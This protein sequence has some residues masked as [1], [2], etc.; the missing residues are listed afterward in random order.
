MSAPPPPTSQCAIGRQLGSPN[1]TR[2]RDLTELAPDSPSTHPDV[3]LRDQFLPKR[4]PACEQ[5]TTPMT[6]RHLFDQ[7]LEPGRYAYG[8]IVMIN[9]SVHVPIDHIL[10]PYRQKMGLASTSTL[11]LARSRR[12]ERPGVFLGRRPKGANGTEMMLMATF[13]GIYKHDDLPRL[14]RL[15][16]LP[17]SP[18][19]GIGATIE[20][21][22]TTPEWQK[23]HGWLILHPFSSLATVSGRWKWKDEDGTYQKECSFKL[24]EEVIS[25]LEEIH[26][27]RFKEW[28]AK[29]S[30]KGYLRECLEEYQKFKQK[31]KNQSKSSVGGSPFV[32]QTSFEDL[33][34]PAVT[35]EQDGPQTNE[36]AQSLGLL[37]ES[38]PLP[39]NAD[40]EPG[41]PIDAQLV[42]SP[43]HSRRPSVSGRFMFGDAPPLDLDPAN[44][45]RHGV[46]FR[47][48]IVERWRRTLS[49][50]VGPRNKLRG[51]A[52]EA[53]EWLN[54][55]LDMPGE[56]FGV[57]GEVFESDDDWETTS[58]ATT[59]S[60]HDDAGPV[61]DETRAVLGGATITLPHV[62]VGQPSGEPVN[63]L[64]PS[65]DNDRGSLGEPPTSAPLQAIATSVLEVCNVSNRPT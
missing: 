45:D 56:P 34:E 38:Q 57:P 42:P 1:S 23:N 16:C 64:P 44:L 27:R 63:E 24:D 6:Q 19:C 53:D 21:L 41:P 11:S 7:A 8:E 28:N 39:G 54:K 35:S 17:I 59:E 43:P 62:Q 31:G 46:G 2:G 50:L 65:A 15:F 18:H 51:I 33:A 61:V 20:H 37:W 3:P 60:V 22:H 12:K 4:D 48:E 55:L 36:N 49:P 26:N 9:E 14:L 58:A 32:P 5:C 29:C 25:Q 30:D 52:F 47:R 13:S 40:V 10:T